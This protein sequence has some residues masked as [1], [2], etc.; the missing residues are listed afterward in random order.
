MYAALAF[1]PVLLLVLTA[2]PVATRYPDAL[3]PAEKAVAGTVDPWGLPFSDSLRRFDA[4]FTGRPNAHFCLG[5]THPLVK[6]WPSKYWFRGESVSSSTAGKALRA[7]EMWAAAGG[8]A[9][10]QVAVLPRMSA[11]ESTYTLRL[12][13]RGGKGAN[14]SAFREVFVKTTEP[15]YPRY[16]VERWPDPL[17]P[18]EKATIGGMDC[19]VFWIDVDVPARHPGG[20]VDVRVTA[21]DG[22]EQASVAIPVHVVPGLAL[23]AKAFPLVAW[24]NAQYGKRT[25]TAVQ[26]RGMYA[27]ALKHHLQ[28]LN[29]LKGRFKPGVTAE[30]DEMHRFLNARG[31]RLFELDPPHGGDAYPLYAHVKKAGWLDRAIIYSNL[32]EPLAGTFIR[33]NVPYCLDIRRRYPGLRVFLAS[34]YYDRMDEGCDIWMTD[35]STTGYD[36][37]KHRSMKQPI[38]WNYYCHLPIHVQFRAPLTQAPNMEVD[39]DALQHRLALW[40]SHHYGA[41]GVFIWAGF[42]PTGLGD[43]FWQTL[44]LGNA[45]SG[46][47]YGGIHNG[48]DFL[49]YPPQTEE[50]LMLPSVRLKVLRDGMEDIALM[51]AARKALDEGRMRGTQAKK[52]RALLNPVPAV[53]VHPHYWDR[54]P[55]TLLTRREAILKVMAAAARAR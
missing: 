11:P 41:Q 52:L 45:S 49:V 29:A 55:E 6:V 37:R 8:T 48:N 12:E 4:R 34:Q 26:T 32:D 42:C 2:P 36:P 9:S 3:P 40:M 25:L 35:L 44:E 16:P 5:V 15:G 23:D 19:G 43:D 50:S 30:F 18:G 14:A 47:P 51:R 28:P 20:V 22:A 13:V 17:I 7:R 53:F 24:F 39:C 38:L 46:Y 31:Q 27:L 1:A 21:T 10:F 54:L 33:E